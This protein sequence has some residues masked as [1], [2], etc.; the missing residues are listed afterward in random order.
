[1]DAFAFT[2]VSTALSSPGNVQLLLIA[3]PSAMKLASVLF[4]AQ[5]QRSFVVEQASLVVGC[6]TNRMYSAVAGFTPSPSPSPSLWAARPRSPLA[7]LTGTV[8]W[9]F[10]VYYS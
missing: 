10:V 8:G 2:L 9:P 6:L 3:M 1:M 4:P 7:G 5:V